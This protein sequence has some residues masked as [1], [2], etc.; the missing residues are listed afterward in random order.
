MCAET[1]Y[2]LGS[3][4]EAL[5]NFGLYNNTFII[6]LSDHGEMNMEHRQVW[7]NSMYEASSRVPL[8][9]SPPPTLASWPCLCS[10]VLCCTWWSCSGPLPWLLLVLL[11]QAC[12]SGCGTSLYSLHT[13]GHVRQN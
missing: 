1:D 3:V 11:D 7:K 5:K 10:R 4:I 8:I 9:I 6:F 13:L 2:M 12:G